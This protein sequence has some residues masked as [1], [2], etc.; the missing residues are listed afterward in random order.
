V[1]VK[2]KVF[3]GQKWAAGSGLATPALDFS[4]NEKVGNGHNADFMKIDIIH[5][6]NLFKSLN[7]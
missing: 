6:H 5:K 2:Q 7:V 3:T 1:W 4:L